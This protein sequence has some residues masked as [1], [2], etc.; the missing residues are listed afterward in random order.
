MT[1]VMAGVSYV[2]KTSFKDVCL[3]TVPMHGAA[4]VFGWCVR[5]FAYR[6]GCASAYGTYCMSCTVGRAGRCET[7]ARASVL[8]R[9][10]LVYVAVV[11]R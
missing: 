5:W 7:A 10:V 3:C 1:D 8:G 4:P 9:A 2:R 6:D 11:G